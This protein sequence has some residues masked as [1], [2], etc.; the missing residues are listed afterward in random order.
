M[1]KEYFGD[2]FIECN[3][4]KEEKGQIYNYPLGMIIFV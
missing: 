3:F 1:W 2:H 4:D